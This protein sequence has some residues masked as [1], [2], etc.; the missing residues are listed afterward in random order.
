MDTGSLNF[1]GERPAV[2]PRTQVPIHR[3]FARSPIGGSAR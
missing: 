2:D 1:S 3:G